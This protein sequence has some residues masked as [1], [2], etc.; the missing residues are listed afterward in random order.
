MPLKLIVKSGRTQGRTQRRPLECA[1]LMAH[2]E[3]SGPPFRSLAVCLSIRMRPSG[4]CRRRRRRWRRC[5]RCRPRRRAPLYLLDGVTTERAGR[6][7]FFCVCVCMLCMSMWAS[8]FSCHHVHACALP[9][10]MDDFVFGPHAARAHRV[11]A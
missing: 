4:G 9:R 3:H 2:A 10:R 5:R 8:V 7:R 6:V 1:T 11:R